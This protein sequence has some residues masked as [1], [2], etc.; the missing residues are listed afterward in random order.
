MAYT[1]RLDG[2]K[3]NELREMSAK[4]GVVPNADGSAEF[5]T[6]KTWAIAAV[7]GP[8]E[9]LPRFMANPKKG[10]VRCQYTM[11]PFSGTGE[12]I[13]PG[14]SRRAQEIGMVMDK[15]LEP[16]VDLT[17]FPNSVVDIF[18]ELPQTDAGTRCAAITAASMA[19]AD[20]GIP[21]RDMVCSVS[22][23]TVDGTVVADLT[24]DEEAYDA[25]VSD[26]PVAMTARTKEIT[27]LQMD[28]HVKKE[29]LN[30]ALELA[31]EV[32]GKVYEVQKKALKAKFME[33]SQ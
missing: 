7:Y 22:V 10:F 15:A 1:K 24:Y 18:V 30:K 31:K 29:E 21:M 23:G 28:G 6:G 27:L 26:I 19:L 2:R 3:V 11:M 25:P 20:A 32:M 17:A 12:R 16:V 13:R 5:R 9:V 14:R 4:V 33:V 8:R